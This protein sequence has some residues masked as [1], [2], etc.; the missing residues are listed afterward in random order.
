MSC[1]ALLCE[2]NIF[3][4][5]IPFKFKYFIVMEDNVSL[6]DD[7]PVSS[8]LKR[9]RMAEDDALSDSLP[10]SFLVKRPRRTRSA[11]SP[12]VP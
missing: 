9:Q 5:Y 6:C 12:K 2:I 7:A 4:S 11:L 10:V 8:L 3:L 1:H